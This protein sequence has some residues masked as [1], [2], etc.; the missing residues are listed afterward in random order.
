MPEVR[1]FG[2]LDFVALL[3]VLALAVAA[4]VGYLVVYCDTA[5][6]AGPLAVED[7]SPVL[8]DVP[9]EVKLREQGRPTELDALVHNVKEHNWFGS[10]APFSSAEEV[11]AH[12][13]PGYPYLLGLLARTINPIDFEPAIRWGQAGLG[14][15]TACFVFLFSRR[16]F[17]S[18][19]VGFLAGLLMAVWPFAVINTA[20][21]TDGTL[22]TFLLAAALWF[23]ARA[24]ATGGPLASLL[25]G[26]A[27]SALALTRAALLPYAG[28]CVLW[29]LGTTRNHRSG[30]L[31]ALVAFLGFFTGIG[32]WVVR[33]HE[34]FHEP[35]PVVS[36]AYY[37]LW[38]GNNPAATGGPVTEEMLALAPANDL[39]KI[40][41]QT[42]RYAALGKLVLKE[43]HEGTGETIQRR[44]NAL[45]YFVFGQRWFTQQ[46]L[47][48]PLAREIPEYSQLIL[49]ASLLGLLLFSFLG[50]RWSFAYRK[51]CV[52]AVLAMCW[53]PLPYILSHAMSLHGP[54]LPLDAVLIAF[55]AFGLA[56]LVPGLGAMLREPQADSEEE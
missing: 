8:D 9:P 45:L 54:R 11:T 46:Q 14:S 30:W 33:N 7:P 37:E 16:V 19:F 48:A 43:V 28:L 41:A 5:R 50:W 3:L 44:I 32:P 15:L 39:M 2:L 6:S 35:V 31:P 51:E 40:P 12:V 22:A 26:L 36:S 23:G 56:G 52:P 49:S 55:A 17:R 53:L 13:S 38:I 10:F 25:F 29:L 21:L 27:L 4:R 47:A 24:G 18:L 42:E 34:Q 20:A 1:R